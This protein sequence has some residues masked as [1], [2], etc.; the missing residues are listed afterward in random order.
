MMQKSGLKVLVAPNSLKGSLDAFGAA[1]AIAGGFAKGCPE[2][3]IAQLAI[4]DGGDAT[5]QV[6]T[7]GLGGS[8]REA[9]VT[10]AL[11]RPQRASWGLLPDGQTAVIDVASATGLG[12]LQPHE[13]DPLRATS[14]GTGELLHAALDIGCRRLIVGV[15]GSATVD[16][17]TGILEAMG[18]RLLNKDGQAVARGGQGLS[19]ICSIDLAAVD[20]RLRTVEI[21]IACDVENPLL[22]AEGAARIFGP[23][24]GATPEVVD[25]LE[26]GLGSF[27]G[28]LERQFGVDVRALPH[29]GAAGGIAATLHAVL[30]AR[31]ERGIDLVL[32][33]L[34]VDSRAAGRDLV[35][36]SEGQVDRQTLAFKGP[37]GVARAAR[38]LGVPTVMVV[39]AISRELTAPDLE[40]FDAVFCLC[41]R[42]MS[43][44]EAMRNAASLLEA[45]AEQIGRMARIAHCGWSSPRP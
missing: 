31:L 40:P 35:I 4:A 29:G 33:Q 19:S 12:A 43:L 15:G 30:G 5:A 45:T 21:T 39:G 16:G 17:G 23:Q 34:D 42:P 28:V 6:L 27:A 9:N 44:E 24:K 3:E 36:T 10:D 8:F 37:Y 18:A 32:Q 25:L 22:G 20:P 38:R 7:R 14:Y 2:A 41:P 11:G 26:A 13:R 1:R